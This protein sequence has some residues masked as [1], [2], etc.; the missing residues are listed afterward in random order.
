MLDRLS[1]GA[2]RTLTAWTF[3]ALPI[4]FFVAIRLYPTADAL[5]TSLTD[6]NIVGPRRSSF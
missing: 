6:W 2:R 4:V 1:L 3:L 5:L